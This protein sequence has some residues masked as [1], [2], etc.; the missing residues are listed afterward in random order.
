MN[1]TCC[2]EIYLYRN[3]QFLFNTQLIS[4]LYSKCET[5]LISTDK[6]TKSVIRLLCS[7]ASI[8]L[9]MSSNRTQFLRMIRKLQS[10]IYNF[11][12]NDNNLS[13]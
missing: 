3:E 4:N 5:E 13:S 11:H 8:N 10:F 7:Q 9:C 12:F 6:L 1:K 2:F